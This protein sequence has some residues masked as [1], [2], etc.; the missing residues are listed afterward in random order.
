[1]NVITHVAEITLAFDYHV[2]KMFFYI[3]DLKQYLI[4][5]NHSWFRRHDAVFNF[6]SNILILIFQFC[7]KY[8]ILFFVKVFVVIS[9]KKQFL[10]SVKSQ[11]VWQ[12]QNLE[13]FSMIFSSQVRNLALFSSQIISSVFSLQ[14]RS[15]ASFSLQRSSSVSSI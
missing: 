11:E 14:V 8:C 12:V 3:T 5:L 1:M 6:D 4:V 13:I 9:E 2:K 7:L 15:L 10:S